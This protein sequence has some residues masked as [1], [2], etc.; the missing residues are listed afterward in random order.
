MT[1]DDLSFRHT[2]AHSLTSLVHS[3]CFPQTPGRYNLVHPSLLLLL[4][5]HA[6]LL[7]LQDHPCPC[8]CPCPPLQHNPCICLCHHL[9]LPHNHC[10]HHPVMDRRITSSFSFYGNEGHG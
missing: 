3:L 1:A 7:L 6:L 8:P 9:C 10:L 4:H 2:S 5:L